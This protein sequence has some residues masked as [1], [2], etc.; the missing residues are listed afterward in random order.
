MRSCRVGGQVRISAATLPG[1]S[2]LGSAS[3]SLCLAS[4]MWLR[5]LRGHPAAFLLPVVST[6]SCHT[7]FPRCLHRESG[8]L[9]PP[10]ATRWD[11][12][13]VPLAAVT[14]Q[15]SSDSPLRWPHLPPEPCSCP[16]P[17][18]SMLSSKNYQKGRTMSS[19]L[20]PHS[21]L[22]SP[23]SREEPARRQG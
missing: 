12:M 17:A 1:A 9:P 7:S 4:G 13:R 2:T 11:E 14:S 3:P 21:Q 5:S 22:R 8:Y 18:V 10:S 6:I 19:D 16:N 20:G 15:H 23:R